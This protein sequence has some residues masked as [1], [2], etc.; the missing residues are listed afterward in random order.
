MV[1]TTQEDI[2][3]ILIMGMVG[4][5]FLAFAIVGFVLFYKRRL[6]KQELAIQEQRIVHQQQV[7]AT[8]IA[9]QDEERKRFAADL[10]DDIGGGI[11][12]VLLSVAKLKSNSESAPQAENIS[13]QLNEVLQTVRKISY[14]I[15][16]PAL[17][18]FG[19]DDALSDLCFTLH[20]SS[21]VQIHYE[22]KGSAARLKF[23]NELAIYR[24]IKELLVNAIRHA[25]ATAI[26]VLISN[27]PSVFSF[28][29]KDDGIGFDAAK[30]TKSAGIRNIKQRTQIIGATI[31]FYATA[32]KGLTV[33]FQLQKEA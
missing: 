22:W 17:E 29:V 9:I 24:I 18:D 33:T 30:I 19:L 8:A 20:E 23:S 11:S 3:L 15:M 21:N 1:E 5:F 26:Q 6:M 32:Q 31:D 4:M 12:T 2:S 25:N 27:S 13:K 10:H 7:L 28:V 16:P 14:N